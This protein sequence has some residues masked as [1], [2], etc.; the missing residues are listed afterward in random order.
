MVGLSVV[1]LIAGMRFATQRYRALSRQLELE[2]R[3]AELAKVQERLA[4]SQKM[5]AL[6]Q[7]TGGLAHDFNNMLAVIVAGLNV[8][9]RRIESGQ[10][11]V[12]SQL[13]SASEGAQRAGQLTK[14]LLSFARRQSLSPAATDVNKL[15][16][17]LTQLLRQSLG[18][19]IHLEFAQ[20]AGLWRAYVDPEELE[21]AIVNLILNARDAMPA[22]GTIAIETANAHLDDDYAAC[23]EGV[24]AGQYVIVA[25]TDTGVGM[26]PETAARA[27]EPL[28]TTKEEGKGTG[29]GLSQ[30]HGFVKQSGGDLAIDSEVGRGTTVRL[31]LPCAHLANISS[32][33]LP[34]AAW[35]I[36]FPFP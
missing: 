35:C 8:M 10:T 24:K 4:Q 21:S 28:F 17:G 12:M 20:S 16:S 34:S 31:Y 27:I 6:G 11:D 30:V 7:L 25:V 3:S 36:I 26:S 15:V 29:L 19:A 5:E 18:E 2:E 33:N 22:G 14:R 1:I 32:R 23:H 13:D 9:R